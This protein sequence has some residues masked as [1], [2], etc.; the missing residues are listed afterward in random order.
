MRQSF[1]VI[2]A[3]LLFIVTLIPA[4][5]LATPSDAD[6]LIALGMPP[7][8]ARKLVQVVNTLAS[9]FTNNTWVTVR[10][11][12]NTANINAI[13]VDSSDNTV[14][15]S[16]ASDE[17]IFQLED[18]ASRLVSLTAASDAALAI[19]FGDA[20]TTATQILTLSGST[21]DADDDSSIRLAGGGAFGTDGTR[22]ATIVIPGEEVSGGSDITYNAG[23]SDTHI[24][25]VAGTTEVTLADDAVTFGVTA[26]GTPL[27]STASVDATDSNTLKI[28]SGSAAADTRGGFVSLIGNEVASVG[29]GI[30]ITAGNVS[31][32]TVDVNLEHSSST[33]NVK[34]TT[35]G[36]V[37]VVDDTGAVTASGQVTTPGLNVPAAN[38]ETV[39]GAGTTVSDAAALS[40][41][42]HIHQITGANGTVGWKFASATAG[43]VEI[44]LNT[45]AGVPKVY[46]VSGGTCN[47]GAADAACTLVTGIVAHVCY[48]TA[49]NAWICS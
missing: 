18:D 17:L 37:F 6:Q 3:T 36:T 5:A 40:A 21:A 26:S 11:A 42:K 33:F 43:Q 41:T 4:V 19:K 44:L 9:P 31:T 8:I 28:A 27:I 20:G 22:G 48:A 13:K 46:A 49:A 16:S 30:D 7:A 35:S 2:C 45:T 12:G 10:N 34:D 32:A 24:F 23:A 29:G 25:Q 15:N 14:I 47:G 1:K 38:F 39:A